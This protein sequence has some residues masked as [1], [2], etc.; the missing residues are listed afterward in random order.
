MI[1]PPGEPQSLVA[2]QKQPS[3]QVQHGFRI[4]SEPVQGNDQRGSRIHKVRGSE[5]IMAVQ[6]DRKRSIDSFFH[7]FGFSTDTE[8][9][10]CGIQPDSCCQPAVRP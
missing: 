1:R 7:C 10:E 8:P 3:R 5:Q 4:G 6:P 2:Y 9:P